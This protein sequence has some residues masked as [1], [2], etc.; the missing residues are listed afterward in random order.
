MDVDADAAFAAST[1]GQLVGGLHKTQ[2]WS[3]TGTVEVNALQVVVLE[4]IADHVEL[5]MPIKTMRWRGLALY[6]LMR[7]IAALL[8]PVLGRGDPNFGS[9]AALE[10]ARTLADD[11]AW[12]GA[13]ERSMGLDEPFEHGDQSTASPTL[14]R[15]GLAVRSASAVSAA[16]IASASTVDGVGGSLAEHARTVALFAGG[17]S[18]SFVPRRAIRARVVNNDSFAQTVGPWRR[19]RG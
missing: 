17:L 15:V 11:S 1:E 7:W 8:D 14:L 19:A 6:G 9:D 12:L 16:M 13:Q 10:V 4:L 2:L 3:T 5:G 18:S